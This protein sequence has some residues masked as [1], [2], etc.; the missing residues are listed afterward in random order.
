MRGSKLARGMTLGVAAWVLSACYSYVTAPPSGMRVGEHVRIRVSG[1]EAERLESTLS[2]S[3]RRL[4][5]ELLDQGDSSIALGVALSL[6]PSSAVLPEHAE[7]R[8]V[9]PR[10]DLEDFELRRLDKLRT[11]LLVGTGVAAVAAIAVAKG[12]SILGGS[13]ATGSPNERR[14]P[15]EIPLF[16]LSF[17]LP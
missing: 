6:P 12:S 3:D 9:I 7:Q 1:A 13:G 5:G 8:V 17:R 11:S 16:R 2:L 15:R 10:A 14:V 4:E